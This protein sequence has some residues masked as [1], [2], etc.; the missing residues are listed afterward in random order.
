MTIYGTKVLAYEWIHIEFG[1]CSPCTA[2]KLR[3]GL[4]LLSDPRLRAQI[5]SFSRPHTD[6]LPPFPFGSSFGAA[7]CA[8]IKS[9]LIGAKTAPVRRASGSAELRA[10]PSVSGT[11]LKTKRRE[12]EEGFGGIRCSSERP[13]NQAPA[14]RLPAAAAA[15]S[16]QTQGHALIEATTAGDQV[17][18]V[19]VLSPTEQDASPASAVRM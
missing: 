1:T 3:C 11:G 5:Q 18:T 13:S 9:G 12:E 16:V 6:G 7:R 15:E 2:L 4:A 10:A 17:F 19:P 14:E 8:L